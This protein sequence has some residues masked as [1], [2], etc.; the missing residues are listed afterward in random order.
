MIVLIN[1]C[2]SNTFSQM[3][4]S[5]TSYVRGQPLL[6]WNY[7]LKSIPKQINNWISSLNISAGDEIGQF[8]HLQNSKQQLAH[9]GLAWKWRNTDKIMNTMKK[10]GF[11]YGKVD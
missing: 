3:P 10:N 8:K 4:C 9:A 6:T 1:N 2:A 5:T 11:L 7:D